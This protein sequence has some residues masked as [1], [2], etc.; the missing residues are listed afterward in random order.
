MRKLRIIQSTREG[1]DFSLEAKIG[2]FW[3]EIVHADKSECGM[4]GTAGASITYG[5][6]KKLCQQLLDDLNLWK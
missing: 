2:P 3:F 4:P 1:I 5:I 6:L